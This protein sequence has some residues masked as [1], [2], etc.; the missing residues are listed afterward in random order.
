MKKFLSTIFAALSLILI[1]T[2]ASYSASYGKGE[3]KLTPSA[4]D[5]FIQYLRGKHTEAP[6]QFIVSSDGS[7][8]TYYYCADGAG[9]CRANI[10]PAIKQCE[11]ETNLDCGVFARG[12]TIIW[13]N[14]INIGKKKSKFSS[15]WSD[16][17][18]RAKLTELGFLGD[19]TSVTTTKKIEVKEEKEDKKKKTKTT[20][21]GLVEELEALNELYEA[22]TLT[23]EEFTKAKDKILSQ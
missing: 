11:S 18:V 23:K 9:N 6:E 15:K 1:S 22:G 20:S 10:S 7:W 12:R 5:F 13:R 3:L 21:S 14:G 19:S 2:G 16:S 8:Y 17:E 4:V